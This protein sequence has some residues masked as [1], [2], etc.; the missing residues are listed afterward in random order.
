[1]PGRAGVSITIGSAALGALITAVTGSQPGFLL[2]FLLVVGTAAAVLAVRPGAVYLIIPV[3]A[4][5]Y[6][7]GAAL[8][9]LVSDRATGTSGTALAVNG[10]QWIASGFIP[11]SVATGL[12]IVTTLM[13]WYASRRG[14][15]VPE[16]GPRDPRRGPQDPGRSQRGPGRDQPG[17]G[18][19]P[20]TGA[21]D[22]RRQQ[23]TR[24]RSERRRSDRDP[25]YPMPAR[26]PRDADRR[27]P[28]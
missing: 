14:Q 21:D 16:R 18:R 2:G 13:R 8:A 23:P 25:D 26:N 3:P 24:T 5:A 22:R 27:Y 1:M 12:A 7:I 15:R 28:G 20:G 6:V 9:G 19:R 11:M 10:T 17:S 4:L